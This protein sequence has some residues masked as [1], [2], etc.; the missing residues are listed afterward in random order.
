MRLMDEAG[1]GQEGKLARLKTVPILGLF[2]DKSFVHYAWTGGLIS[3]LNVF[4]LWFFIDNLHMS[5]VTASVIVICGTFLL[6]YVLL[7]YF[8]V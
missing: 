6:L 4:L 1:V 2:F 5:T 7:R 3:V 8:K